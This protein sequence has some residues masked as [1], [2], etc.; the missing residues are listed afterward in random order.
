MSLYE[1]H[2]VRVEYYAYLLDS[3]KG[4]NRTLEQNK[5][6][7]N[8]NVKSINFVLQKRRPELKYFI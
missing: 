5:T 6:V 8:N 3:D 1:L 2:V 4:A 7:V